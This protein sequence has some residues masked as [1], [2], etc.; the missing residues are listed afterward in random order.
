MQGIVYF[1]Q[2]PILWAY[3]FTI[4]VPQLILTFI[5]YT[6]FYAFL[7]PPQA[8]MAIFFNG[9]TGIF[10]ASLALMHESSVAAQL[11]SNMFLLPTPLKLLFDAVMSREGQ[12]ELVLKAKLHD[13]VKSPGT[14]YKFKQYIKESPKS[15]MM[16]GWMLKSLLKIT[17]HFIPIL[18]PLIIVVMDGPKHGKRLHGRYF[19]LKQM[20]SKELDAYVKDRRGQYWGFGIIAGMLENVPFMGFAFTFTNVVG[21]ALWAAAVERKSQANATSLRAAGRRKAVNYFTRR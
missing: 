14:M 13:R 19:E 17:L 11:I 21:A 8:A 4:L 12:D 15:M 18:G 3:L 6:L 5:V 7:Y 20:D 2:N 16:P 9:P 1:T 10:T